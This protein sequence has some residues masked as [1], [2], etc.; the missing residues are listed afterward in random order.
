MKNIKTITAVTIFAVTFIFSAGLV[1]LII[2]APV[3]QYVY[4]ERPIE[5]RSNEIE[6]FLLRDI[7]NGTVR[8]D[9]SDT[10]DY[11]EAVMNYWET[12]SSMN[13]SAFPSDFQA[14]WHNH[15]QA[16]HNY[17]EYLAKVKKSSARRE[18]RESNRLNNEI[19]R[20]WED[21]KAIGRNH[22][23]QLR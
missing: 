5:R 2:P 16:W 12:S 8:M 23:S 20:T 3:V 9:D 11:A 7:Q 13:D 21:V 19:N 6:N 4:L 18:T 14:A 17:G 10:D 22:G 15:M 1:R